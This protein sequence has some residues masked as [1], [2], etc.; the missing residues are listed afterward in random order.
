MQ[1]LSS[2]SLDDVVTTPYF[3]NIHSPTNITPYLEPYRSAFHK[4]MNLFFLSE[5]LDQIMVWN[6]ITYGEWHRLVL[7]TPSAREEGK[8]EE[9]IGIGV[10]PWDKS[11]WI[12]MIQGADQ[13]HLPRN[14][15][16]Y[17]LK[18]WPLAAI[19]VVEDIAF[20]LQFEEVRI[21]KAQDQ[22]YFHRPY[23]VP[24]D[25][26]HLVQARLIER[27][28]QN[29]EMLGFIEEHNCYSKPIR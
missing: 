12:R 19:N 6:K 8:Y 16:Y 22:P 24:Q 26:I 28:N 10:L 9:I 15:G 11:L 3:L 2:D 27:Y 5:G 21:R 13:E 7:G 14:F 23:G 17:A 20:D 18:N 1:R 25:K 29:A 4:D